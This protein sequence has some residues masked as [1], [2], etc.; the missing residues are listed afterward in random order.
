[1]QTLMYTICI[2]I[3]T[4]ASHVLCIHCTHIA[5][6]EYTLRA[7]YAQ[8]IITMRKHL[9]AY[10]CILEHHMYYAYTAHT[11]HYVNLYIEICTQLIK[12]YYSGMGNVL[13]CQ[14]N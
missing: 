13:V 2:Y 14:L 10:T 7:M 6:C 12:Y 5:L 3:H 1:M 8:L 4:R 11:L 9:Y